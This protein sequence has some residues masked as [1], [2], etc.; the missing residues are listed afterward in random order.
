MAT[1]GGRCL[2]QDCQAAICGGRGVC[3]DECLFLKRLLYQ[4][5]NIVSAIPDPTQLQVVVGQLRTLVPNISDLAE[6]TNVNSILNQILAGN[7]TNTQ[8]TEF[9]AQLEAAAELIAQPNLKAQFL[10]YKS[11]LR[12]I[13][14]TNAMLEVNVSLSTIARLSPIG[15]IKMIFLQVYGYRPSKTDPKFQEMMTE[16]GV[17]FYTAPA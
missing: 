6:R 11:T 4:I 7:L 16:F 10:G 14:F 17:S 1:L 13:L 5:Q 2:G 15:T 12:D 8:K 9:I 3:M